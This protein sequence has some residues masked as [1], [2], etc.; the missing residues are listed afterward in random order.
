MVFIMLRYVPSVGFPGSSDGKE[1]TCNA[2]NSGSI[3]GSG[4]SPEEGIGSALQYSWTS[5]VAQ[6]VKNP[7]VMWETWVQ[8]LGWEDPLEEGK[9]TPP[10]FLPG[11]SQGQG[12]LAGYSKWGRKEST[13]L[14]TSTRQSQISYNVNRIIQNLREL[15]RS[16][17]LCFKY[18][19]TPELLQSAPNAG[20]SE[21][22]F[23][24][25]ALDRC[26]ISGLC[27]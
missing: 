14:N 4:R 6:M 3:P 7:P 11:E 23:L 1:Y 9:A 2:G 18:F 27:I 26:G 24:S 8:S 12:S 19:S 5:L 10:V 15:R 13:Q 22:V 17:P 16:H 25:S 20:Q 21:Q